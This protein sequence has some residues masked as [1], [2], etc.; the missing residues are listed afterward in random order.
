MYIDYYKMIT[1]KLSVQER[2]LY[3]EWDWFYC[4]DDPMGTCCLPCSAVQAVVEDLCCC[5]GGGGAERIAKA[6]KTREQQRDVERSFCSRYCAVPVGRTL[7]LFDMVSHF[8]NLASSCPPP[9]RPPPPTP[10][11]NVT[12]VSTD[13]IIVCVYDCS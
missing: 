12:K 1:M 9:P 11:C 2:V 4:V 6:H 7:S 10:Q 5:G 3:T 8:K 13:L